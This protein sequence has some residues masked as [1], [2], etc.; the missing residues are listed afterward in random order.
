M[1]LPT[2]IGSQVTTHQVVFLDFPFKGTKLKY[3]SKRS[4]AILTGFMNHLLIP[5]AS[6][7]VHFQNVQLM[8]VFDAIIWFIKPVKIFFTFEYRRPV[9]LC[10]KIVVI[11]RKENGKI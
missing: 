4:N 3:D 8:N 11:G 5:D 9:F 1:V 6:T 7:V 2:R 10:N